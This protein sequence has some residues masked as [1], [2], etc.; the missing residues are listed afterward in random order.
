MTNGHGISWSFEVERN[1]QCS[2]PESETG[3]SKALSLDGRFDP[4]N[5]LEK[6]K[7]LID[8]QDLSATTDRVAVRFVT[9]ISLQKSY[10][11]LSPPNPIP[12]FGENG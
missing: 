7:N 1:V 8:T 2:F 10:A 6:K 9:R 11:L 3:H 12:N 5:I 4:D